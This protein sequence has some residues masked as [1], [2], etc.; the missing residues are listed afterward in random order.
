MEKGVGIGDLKEIEVLGEKIENVRIQGFRTAKTFASAN[1]LVRIL[2]VLFHQSMTPKPVC[3][4]DK[5]T[6][7]GTCV[8]VCPPKAMCVEKNKIKIDYKSCIRCFCCSEVCP[9][10]AMDIGEGSLLKFINRMQKKSE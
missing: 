10:D 4:H 9:E 8:K 5:C 1:L 6:A 2:P 3:I 7:C